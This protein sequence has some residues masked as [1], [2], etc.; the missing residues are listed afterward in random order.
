LSTNFE[1]HTGG[2]IG[3]EYD[4]YK[5]TFLI[6]SIHDRGYFNLKS[7]DDDT[8]VYVMTHDVDFDAIDESND[9]IESNQIKWKDSNISN[10]TFTYYSEPNDC[11]SVDPF[12]PVEITVENNSI[13]NLYVP[14]LGTNLDIS[15]STYP[16]INDVFENMINSIEDI[17]GTPSFDENFGYPLNYETDISDAE[18]DGYSI[19]ISSFI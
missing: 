17:E 12:P 4:L 2:G 3:D 11:P 16:T 7:F 8:I 14:Q 18:C 6:E 1:Q 5:L 13:T 15:T 19:A 9:L 10:Y